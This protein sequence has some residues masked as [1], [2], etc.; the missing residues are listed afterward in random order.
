MLLGLWSLYIEPDSL[1][2]NDVNLQIPNWPSGFKIRIAVLSDI[3]IGMPYC[4]EDKLKLIVKKTNALKPDL[5]IFLGDFDS[6]TIVK[7]GISEDKIISELKKLKA[8][9]GVYSIL[10][11]HD[12]Q[13]KENKLKDLRYIPVL[14]IHKGKYQ[15]RLIETILE[16]SNILLLENTYQKIMIHNKPLWLIGFSDRCASKYKLKKI[17]S[18]LPEDEPKILLNHRPDFFKQVPK[19]INLTLAGHT[20]GGQIRLPFIGAPHSNTKYGYTK[21]HITENNRHL[22]VTSGIGNISLPLRLGVR[23]EIVLLTIK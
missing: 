4:K 18:K 3:H 1:E 23:P 17:L 22:F 6:Y 20:H 16:K 21:G 15:S 10:G 5:I 7:S 8:P 13:Y 2:I 9:Y 11:N 12:K 19:D 14:G